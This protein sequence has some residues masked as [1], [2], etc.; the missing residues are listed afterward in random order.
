VSLTL[1]VRRRNHIK[2]G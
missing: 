1:A 2:P